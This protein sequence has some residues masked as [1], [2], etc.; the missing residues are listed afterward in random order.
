VLVDLAAKRG[1]R[2]RVL[3]ME[4]ADALMAMITQGL[5]MEECQAVST[6]LPKAPRD[7]PGGKALSFRGM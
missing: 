3:H 4:D 2:Q 7:V 5:S 6:L 1:L